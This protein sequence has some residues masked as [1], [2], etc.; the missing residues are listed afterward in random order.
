MFA[1]YLEGKSF[2]DCMDC[3]VCEGKCPQHL[4][5]RREMERV[6]GVLEGL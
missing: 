3:G 2:K 1:K 5:I 4:E 6:E